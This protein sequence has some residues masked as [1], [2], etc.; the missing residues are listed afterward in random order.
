MIDHPYHDHVAWIE[1][2]VH[3]GSFGKMFLFPKCKA[4]RARGTPFIL[5]LPL[6]LIRIILL[7][8]KS[9]QAMPAKVRNTYMASYKG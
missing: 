6:V 3:C 4:Y 1:N 2:V 7:I 5:R 8:V 9:M